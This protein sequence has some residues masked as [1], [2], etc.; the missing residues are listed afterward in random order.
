MFRGRL[1]IQFAQNLLSNEVS[2]LIT[3]HRI[4]RSFYAILKVENPVTSLVPVSIFYTKYFWYKTGAKE[5][6]K[7][8]QNFADYG[9]HSIF[10]IPVLVG[11]DINLVS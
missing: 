7:M 10:F 5:T 11:R 6:Y 8:R 4:G 3:L 9:R 1:K 2:I